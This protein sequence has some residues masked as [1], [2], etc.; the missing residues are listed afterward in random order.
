MRD[1]APFWD[2][3]YSDRSKKIQFFINHLDE[4]LMSYLDSGHV[5]AGKVLELGCGPERNAIYLAQNGS[6]KDTISRLF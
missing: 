5:Q 3:F 2:K 6:V 1:P 4:N